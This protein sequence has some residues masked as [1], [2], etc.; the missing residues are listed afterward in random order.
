MAKITFKRL[1]TANKNGSIPGKLTIGAKSWPTIERSRTHTFV[2]KGEYEVLMCWKISGRRVKCLCFHEDRAISSHLIHDAKNDDHNQLSGCIAP[3]L[4]SSDTGIQDSAKAMG[5]VFDALG[6]FKLWKK[7]DIIVENNIKGS[8][9]KE[10]WITR[11]KKE[12]K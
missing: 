12:K 10:D 9:K 11:R 5:Q 7:V 3:G 4:S 1:G 2:R 8:E 6:G